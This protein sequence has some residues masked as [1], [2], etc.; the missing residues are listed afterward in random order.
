MCSDKEGTGEEH[1]NPEKLK[2]SCS[3]G[4]PGQRGWCPELAPLIATGTIGAEVT[5]GSGHLTVRSQVGAT[6]QWAQAGAAGRAQLQRAEEV[7]RIAHPQVFP[8]HEDG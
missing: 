6:M 7:N 3:H 8:I 2:D 5:E 1:Q 4:L